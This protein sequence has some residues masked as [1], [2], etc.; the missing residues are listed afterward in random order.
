[1]SSGGVPL[2]VAFST[3]GGSAM[4]SAWQSPENHVAMSAGSVGASNTMRTLGNAVTQTLDDAPYVENRIDSHNDLAEARRQHRE[5]QAAALGSIHGCGAQQTPTATPVPVT[6]PPPS[7]PIV[8]LHKAAE[9]HRSAKTQ[10]SVFIGVLVFFVLVVVVL[11]IIW[12]LLHASS[13]PS[14]ASMYRFSRRS[15]AGMPFMTSG[16]RTSRSSGDAA[17]F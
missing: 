14:D 5:Q 6:V 12:G 17:Y 11:L 10:R 4:A 8:D 7:V 16:R 3:G 9:R 2:D 15:A 13:S 1:M